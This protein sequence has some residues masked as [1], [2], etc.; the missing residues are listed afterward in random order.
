MIISSYNLFFHIKHF[1]IILLKQIFK[2]YNF[3][4][5]SRYLKQYISVK[6]IME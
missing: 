5:S 4:T 1:K 3:E 6:E 2:L